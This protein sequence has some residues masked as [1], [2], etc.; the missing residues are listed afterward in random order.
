MNPNWP[1]SN[2]AERLNRKV[3]LF[4]GIILLLLAFILGI[5]SQS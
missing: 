4:F 5:S 3:L 2:E 1:L